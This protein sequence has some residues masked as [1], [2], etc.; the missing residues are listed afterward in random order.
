MGN[1]CGAN[2]LGDGIGSGLRWPE[3]GKLA[4]WVFV[5]WLFNQRAR[6]NGSVV[7]SFNACGFD[8]HGFQLFSQ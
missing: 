3:H 5:V 2:S 4:E 8:D 1:V 7:H 6:N